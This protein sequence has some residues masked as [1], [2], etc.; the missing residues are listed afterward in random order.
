MP[1]TFAHPAAALPLRRIG[2]LR[3]PLLGL[4]IG[5]LVPD[6]GYY[7]GHYDLATFAHSL[8]GIAIFC[9]PVGLLLIVLSLKARHF[10]AA[11]LPEPHRTAIE[12]LPSPPLWPISQT[13]KMAAAVLLG[14]MT[15]VAWDSFT[16][17]SGVVTLNVIVLRK[18]LFVLAGHPFPLYNVLQHASTLIGI[19]VLS[20]AYV[21]WLKRATSPYRR[22]AKTQLSGYVPLAVSAA[23][24]AA[25]GFTISFLAAKSESPFSALI[26]RG[27]VYSTIIFLTA[28]AGLA[29]RTMR[30]SAV[31]K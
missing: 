7:V 24:S 25:L 10:L 23:L 20:I 18:E 16:H 29:L 27:I 13:T 1:W 26:V 2:P 28:Y 19:S 3:L 21:H 31:D 17:A 11:P 6:L 12:H 8:R 14:A 15:H 22:D 9:I 5:S 4:I 30:R